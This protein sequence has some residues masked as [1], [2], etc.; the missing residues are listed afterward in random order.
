[1]LPIFTSCS[2]LGD[3]DRVSPGAQLADAGSQQR[4]G[5]LVDPFPVDAGRDPEGRLAVIINLGYL[6]RYGDV[7][8]VDR[9]RLLVLSP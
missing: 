3:V 4:P 6:D 2:V 8:G 9:Q 1:M 7:L 5:G